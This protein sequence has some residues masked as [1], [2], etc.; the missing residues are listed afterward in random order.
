M[1]RILLLAAAGGLGTI[2]RYGLALGVGRLH[3]GPFPWGT[4]AVNMLGVFAFGV[5]W[6]LAD[7]RMVIGGETRL[8][9]LTGFVGGFTTFSTFL[10][11][12]GQ[13]MRDAEWGM[14]AA[15]LLGQSGLGLVLLFAGMALGRLV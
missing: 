14:A 6:A 1:Q 15:N 8:V 2:A 9:L 12:T 13:L 3:S 11:E 7:D 10:F 5:I 4:F